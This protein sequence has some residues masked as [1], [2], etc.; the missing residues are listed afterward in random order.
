MSNK[1]TKT[2]V[3]LF[4]VFIKKPN[5]LPFCTKN[6]DKKHLH[7]LISDYIAGMTDR[8]A[9]KEHKRILKSIALCSKI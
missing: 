8:Y 3:E 1:A 6:I 2:I 4:N 9:I 7:L 5:L